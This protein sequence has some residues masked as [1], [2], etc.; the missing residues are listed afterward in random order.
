[1]LGGLFIVATV[2]VFG[3]IAILAGNLGEW[4]NKSER[5]QKIL[6]KIAGTVFVAL[7]IKL[8]IAEH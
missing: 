2:L 6:N 4:L 7:A 3:A 5:T 1:M 8:A